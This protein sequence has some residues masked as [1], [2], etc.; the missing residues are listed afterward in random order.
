MLGLVG[1]NTDGWSITL[2]SATAASILALSACTQITAQPADQPT[3]NLEPGLQGPT[4]PIQPV[5][6]FRIATGEFDLTAAAAFGNPGFHE[7]IQLTH[8]F[9]SALEPTAGMRIVVALWDAGRPE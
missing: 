8:T 3:A 9:P 2:A 6:P 4:I 1:P 5:S 7:A